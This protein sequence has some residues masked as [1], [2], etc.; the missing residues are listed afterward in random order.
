MDPSDSRTRVRVSLQAGELEVEGSESFVAG[1]ADAIDAL[2][3]RVRV[4]EPS[5]EAP[6]RDTNGTRAS[7]GL[8]DDGEFPEALHRMSS[9]SGT[10][11][12]LVAGS[13]AR[14][15]HADGTFST[16]EANAL[17]LEQGI[18]LANASQSMANN[19]KA[20]RVFRAGKT[21]KISRT[22]EEYIKTLV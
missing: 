11:Q 7:V 12:I 13:F 17:L 18:K 8:H 10:D 22:G 14:K 20:K 4:E 16:T 2:I 15:N 1:Y 5:V 19:L 9:S 3:A 6:S 21:W